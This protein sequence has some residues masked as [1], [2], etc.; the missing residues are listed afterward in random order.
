MKKYI[1]GAAALV[2]SA[3]AAVA[4]GLA[5]AMIEQDPTIVMSDTIES[6]GS[7]PGWV[8]PVV[9]L[10]VVALAVAANSGDDDDDENDG[11]G[12]NGGDDDYNM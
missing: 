2:G 6:A 12:S 7:V 10:G 1:L 9:I 3:A 5:D 11:N 4:G 8:I